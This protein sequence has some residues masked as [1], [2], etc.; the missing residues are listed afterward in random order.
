MFGTAEKPEDVAKALLGE[1]Y[2]DLGRRLD[3]FTGIVEAHKCA[4][5][6]DLVLESDTVLRGTMEM[7]GIKPPPLDPVAPFGPSEAGRQARV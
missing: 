5:V 4:G 7:M 3:R 6:L 2:T 1:R